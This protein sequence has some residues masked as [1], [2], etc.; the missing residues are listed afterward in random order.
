MSFHASRESWAVENPVRPASNLYATDGSLVD[1]TASMR[2]RL[3]PR[4]AVNCRLP[5]KMPIERPLN[6]TSIRAPSVL[7]LQDVVWNDEVARRMSSGF[8]D[9]YSK[10]A[11][12]GRATAPAAAAR[13]L[14]RPRPSP[15]HRH[16]P[17]RHR[18]RRARGRCG[19]RDVQRRV[20]VGVPL[21]FLSTL[22]RELS[23]SLQRFTLL[24]GKSPNAT[25][26]PVLGF[27]VL[28]QRCP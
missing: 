25:D 28:S 17:A 7:T 6:V 8:G 13:R 26:D 3:V 2:R 23:K 14:P 10:P 1:A 5:E 19:R 9:V 4:Y 20:A 22:G 18:G 21:L 16:R 11:A 24:A 12:Q 27:Q 15:H